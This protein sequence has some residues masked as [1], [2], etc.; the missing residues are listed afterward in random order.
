MGQRHQAFLIA[1]V[2]PHGSSE[3]NYRCIAAYHHQWCYGSLP[4][5]ATRRL[6]TL[7]KQPENAEIIREEIR[8][9]D[10]KQKLSDVP[11]PFASTIVG[12]AWNVDLSEGNVMLS[13]VS[14]ENNLLPTSMG[15][16]DGD[17]NDGITV[18]DVTNPE[19]PSYC[20]LNDA[21]PLTGE[22]YIAGY[23]DI[24]TIRSILSGTAAG[25]DALEARSDDAPENVAH[26]ADLEA[27][28]QFEKSVL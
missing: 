19:D 26:A 2:K 23:Y 8:A 11:C 22:Q 25:T 12:A 28:M 1:K 4:L 17:N 7:V 18:I 13:G 9:I 6:L 21:E 5:R 3:A 14:L 15:C 16:W 20:F 27:T 10:G 24:K